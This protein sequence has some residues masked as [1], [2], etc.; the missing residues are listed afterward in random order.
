LAGMHDED[1]SAIYMYLMSLDP[2]ESSIVKFVP[3]ND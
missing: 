2:I 3:D 1:L